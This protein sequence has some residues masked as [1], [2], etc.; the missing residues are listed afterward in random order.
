MKKIL[1][2]TYYWPPSGGG[3]VQRWLKFVK[4]LPQAGWDPI[5]VAPQNA[6][7]PTTDESLLR[8]ID[9][10][11]E[12]IK[13]PIWEPY[14][15]F[16]ILTGKKKDA[17][18]NSGVLTDKSK[19]SLAE[20]ISIWIRGN[21]LIPDPRI[22]WVNPAKKTLKKYLQNNSVDAIITTGPPHSV[23]LIGYKLKK[24]LGIKWLADFRDPWSGIDY[25][26]EFNPGK[27][28]MN[29]QKKLEHKVITTAD[30]VITVSENWAND[31]KIL[32]A[33]NIE[34][35]TNGYD[36][37]DFAGFNYNYQSEDF[38]LLYSGI[39]HAYRNPKYLW[40]ALEKTCKTDEYFA[41]KIKLKLFGTIDDEVIAYLES[42]PFL[43]KRFYYGGY[44]SHTALIQ[45]YAKATVL[46]LLQNNTKNAM[47]HIPGK[48]FE[49]LASGKHIA[50]LCNSNS[51]VA[52]IL[53]R[54]D[55]GTIFNE[56]TISELKDLFYNSKK[57]KEKNS[58]NFEKKFSRNNLT[59]NLVQLLNA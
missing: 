6:E 44:I 28:A 48:L 3:G 26:E 27:M 45:E 46:L 2:I 53:S 24:S 34:V 33:K 13:I 4:Y 55:K 36:E 21:I 52:K 39:I 25:L 37:K 38:T 58:K 41:S 40:D 47:G 22:F 56:N 51:D 30:Q 8:D 49:Y 17:K 16:K 20:R 35:I 50:A 5:V 29:K 1:I 31:L 19:Q 10:K 11:L 43:S 42:L 32:G 12:V 54:Y 57:S 18:V 15:L 7:Y 59:T 23:H 9:P 14:N